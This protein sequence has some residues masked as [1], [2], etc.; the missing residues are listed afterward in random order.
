MPRVSAHSAIEVRKR[1]PLGDS[2]RE[3]SAPGKGKK[4]IPRPQCN[5]DIHRVSRLATAVKKWKLLISGSS[6]ALRA[7]LV[8]TE[9]A[10]IPKFRR[11][12]PVGIESDAQRPDKPQDW[13]LAVVSGSA[14]PGEIEI[15]FLV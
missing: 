10:R 5:G 2:L 9:P 7:S 11:S 12:H 6:G 4:E 3:F 8:K 15:D 13:L 14:P 1:L